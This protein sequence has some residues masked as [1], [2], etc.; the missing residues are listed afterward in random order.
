MTE[1]DQEAVYRMRQEIQTYLP[2]QQ[3]AQRP[4]GLQNAQV[5]V[6]NFLVAVEDLAC[7]AV[8]VVPIAAVAAAASL[9]VASFA[10][11]LEASLAAAMVA[12]F[13]V[14]QALAA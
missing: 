6:G 5:E 13:V 12:P 11:A 8:E 10:A 3:V 9:A 1:L 14:Y 4:E 2:Q 7:L